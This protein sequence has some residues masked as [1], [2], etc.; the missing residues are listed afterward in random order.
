MGP[1]LDRQ[2]EHVGVRLRSLVGAD[3]PGSLEP[4]EDA[5]RLEGDEARRGEIRV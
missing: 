2:I 1:L 4:P 5:R 3:L